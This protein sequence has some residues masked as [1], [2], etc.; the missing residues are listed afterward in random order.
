MHVQVHARLRA[1]IVATAKAA[2]ISLIAPAITLAAPVIATSPVIV[3]VI[4]VLTLTQLD[5][6]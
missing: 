6:L 5:V 3:L 1:R 4:A 2:V